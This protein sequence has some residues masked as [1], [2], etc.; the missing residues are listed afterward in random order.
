MS[1]FKACRTCGRA[2]HRGSAMD[3]CATCVAAG[4]MAPERLEEIDQHRSSVEMLSADPAGSKDASPSAGPLALSASLDPQ[5]GTCIGHYKL[6]QKIG[7]GGCGIVYMAEQ[8]QPIRRS[9]ALKLIKPGLD[10]KHV[11][12]RFEAERQA[13]AMMDHPCIARVLDG[14]S[15]ASADG[16]YCGRPYFVMELIRGQ[17][18]SDYCDQTKLSTSDRLEL[19]VQVCQAIQHAHQKGIIH[20][21]LKP[22]NILVAQNDGVAVPKVIDFGIAKAISGQQLTDRTLFT[23][24]DKFIGTP[25][26]M[27][28][29]QATMT[30][31]DIDTRS[32]IYSLGVLLYEL[33]TGRTP[34]DQR[35]LV[36]LGMDRL[37]RT[38]CEREPLRPSARL[39]TLSRDDLTT[40]AQRRSSDPPRLIQSIRG[41]LDWIVM[42]CLEKD[43]SRR[44]ATAHE[45]IADIRRHQQG[46]PISARAPSHWY[47][48]QRLAR[49]HQASFATAGAIAVILLIGC[50]LSTG[51]F[52][53]ERASR[54]HAT[55][56]EAA[57]ELSAGRAE[58][59]AEESRQ[60]LLQ[61]QLVNGTRFLDDGDLMRALP[62]FV[63]AFKTDHASPEKAPVHQRR[64]ASILQQCPRPVRMWFL[65]G[66][67]P[68]VA[69]SPDGSKV[70]AAASSGS[71]TL[72][73][74]HSGRQLT[75]ARL[76]PDVRDNDLI[77]GGFSADGT[78]AFVEWNNVA[79]LW[80]VEKPSNGYV[81]IRESATL[82]SAAISPDG[83]FL[84]TSV[85]KRNP[86]VWNAATG[87]RLR[88][89]DNQ[90]QRLYTCRLLSAEVVR[91]L[92]DVAVADSA[93]LLVT[94]DEGKRIRLWDVSTAMLL[95][96]NVSEECPD[97][98]WID[99]GA[100]SADGQLL[101]LSQNV[102]GDFDTLIVN[103]SSAQLLSRLPHEHYVYGVAFTPDGRSV[104]TCGQD[105]LVRIFEA[106]T[107]RGR[108][109]AKRHERPIWSVSISPGGQFVAS[110]SWDGTSSIWDMQSG[111]RVG[112]PL[113][114]SGSAPGV[115]FGNSDSMLVTGDRDGCVRVWDLAAAPK[116]KW[117]T[118]YRYGTQMDSATW[119]FHDPRWGAIIKQVDGM[120]MVG[121][122]GRSPH[123]VP[124]EFH[125]VVG[126]A[127]SRDRTRVIVA[128][129]TMQGYSYQL[130]SGENGKSIGPLITT[131]DSMLHP[132]F[133]GYGD[134]P[135]NTRFEID[136]PLALPCSDDTS[137]VA[138]FSDPDQI[139]VWNTVSGEQVG[140]TI[141]LPESIPNWFCWHTSLIELSPD[142]TK[143]ASRRGR[144]VY[145]WNVAD[146]RTCF[147]ELEHPADVVRK[148]E[149]S[150][151]GQR[152][153]TAC[154]GSSGE[155]YAQV[156]N[157][158]TGKPS[159]ERM[160]HRAELKF[161]AFSHGGD[162]IVTSDASGHVVVWD[163]QTGRR[164]A[165]LMESPYEVHTV[166]F[167]PDDRII[168]AAC[169][170]GTVRL[171]DSRTGEMLVA[172]I[173][174]STRFTLGYGPQF[175]ML[176]S[177]GQT[178]ST[179]HSG[180]RFW[181]VPNTTRPL[182]DW[183]RIAQFLSARST[184][185]QAMTDA[186]PLESTRGLWSSV[187]SIA[188]NEFSDSDARRYDWHVWRAEAELA[189]FDPRNALP[190]LDELIA[191]EPDRLRFRTMRARAHEA[192]LNW[193]SMAE[194]LQHATRLS[195][196]DH[197]LWVQLAAAQ[198]AA[199]DLPGYQ[200]AC[201]QVAK[202][203][204]TAIDFH[205]AGWSIRSC[206][207]GP[208]Q[209]ETLAQL[210]SHLDRF[211]SQAQIDQKVNGL[212][213]RWN[214]QRTEGFVAFRQ[215]QYEEAL[216]LLTKVAQDG[217]SDFTM[218][219]YLILAMTH[220]ALGHP[221]EAKSF[222]E[223]GRPKRD[224]TQSPP[225]RT[226]GAGT[227]ALH[228][229]TLALVR[230]A[231][232]MLRQ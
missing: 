228:G 162:R 28:P 222:L 63:E 179:F 112:P 191:R 217:I 43:R 160:I 180:M 146:G 76:A 52:L 215:G 56:A 83:H 158:S 212:G 81:E 159:G 44:Y 163:A 110:G 15:T 114:H 75:T 69:V 14:G 218:D 13:L 85:G 129:R 88:E 10:T 203:L 184:E 87:E 41:D 90:G 38:I 139:Q 134:G 142:G 121:P 111:E 204:E 124:G 232:K 55:V 8:Q 165:P 186:S 122:D 33:L 31:V 171:F 198:L 135:I 32:D 193:S 131:G 108:G 138:T 130:L 155:S 62:W 2:I 209:A 11:L 188:P 20:R 23:G 72:W 30:S 136:V 149:F 126:A 18:L 227:P 181:E 73:D 153:L 19:F 100:F 86:I 128:R 194:D 197:L 99:R 221:D 216:N 189:Q 167:S 173:A 231:E 226:M 84:V 54:L 42:K 107:G 154:Q 103:V 137:R 21:D 151:D 71:A 140:P 161:A 47:L 182:H 199:G 164:D 156:W 46:D 36:E 185:A 16:T 12:G 45:M 4:L 169:A 51:M 89:L 125:S 79:I 106:R 7:E 117:V 64:L 67:V 170:D 174:H 211:R 229:T 91:R 210:R 60:R 147:P 200:D 202:H 82:Q 196:D 49:R 113:V 9:V 25:A 94:F 144:H 34:F 26:Y 201:R 123:R 39:S 29:E 53:R 59:L 214:H 208:N 223:K 98:S 27:S 152:L 105:R 119:G 101:A 141:K 220:H 206:C 168:V 195:P 116:W 104:V 77:A 70:L 66:E 40:T 183:E 224:L 78:R 61:L 175:A 97:P 58:A 3:V 132:C 50:M 187:Q 205:D 74:L 22:S 80:D 95:H 177:A 37:Y 213:F 57:A 172:P 92:F 219:V 1:T 109:V 145:V 118:D 127:V 6:L 35:E 115:A 65:D 166:Y 192:L 24:F 48:I 176:L 96:E 178:L 93:Q 68:F 230:E 157:A 225:Q 17:R 148:I 190:H 5:A 133:Y 102:S 207:H 120:L 143:V 150:A